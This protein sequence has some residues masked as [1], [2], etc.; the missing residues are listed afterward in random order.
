MKK[1]R[2]L[3]I[4]FLTALCALSLFAFAS[5]S[6]SEADKGIKVIYKLNGGT[7]KNS[8]EDVV[9]YYK[10]PDGAKKLIKAIPIGGDGSAK[11]EQLGYNFAGWYKDEECTVPW[12]FET[13]VVGD[14]GVTLYADWSKKTQYIYSI[15]YMKDGEFE[16][17][18]TAIAKPL[19]T[20][21]FSLDMIIDAAD[22]REGYTLLY[23]SVKPDESDYAKYFDKDGI[24][25]EADEDVTIKVYAEYIEG[26]YLLLYSRDD[27][28]TLGN[29]DNK[30]KGKTLLL[31]N[32]IDCGGQKLGDG[33]KNAFAANDK[34]MPNYLGIH[35][36]DPEGKGVK[37]AISNFAV[38]CSYIGKVQTP[39][40]ASIFADIGDSGE[41]NAETIV[42]ITG[43]NFTGVTVNADVGNDSISRLYVSSFADNVYNAEITNVNVSVKVIASKL[44]GSEDEHFFYEAEHVYARETENVKIEN[45][46]FVITET[47]SKKGEKIELT[48]E[49]A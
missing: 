15:G 21:D 7:Y 41:A 1:F 13:D 4:L 25:K 23:N 6:G 43:V 39:L 22:T 31:M 35:S 19:L 34:G 46:D 5:C 20:F 14:E 36:Y 11:V 37:Y 29:S 8:E 45:C 9:I 48:K 16:E 26:N 42:K 40:T 27:L 17:V 33:F 30:L 28:G 38:D 2:L 18:N 47:V 3:T 44:R 10:Y 49:N 12:N 24:L 32:D